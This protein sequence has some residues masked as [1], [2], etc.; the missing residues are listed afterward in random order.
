M[1]RVDVRLPGWPVVS[2][3]SN[4]RETQRSGSDE[5]LLRSTAVTVLAPQSPVTALVSSFYLGRSENP[6]IRRMSLDKQANTRTCGFS[7]Q[8]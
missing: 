6:Q 4:W 1:D 7:V 5:L 8:C 3:T 2:T